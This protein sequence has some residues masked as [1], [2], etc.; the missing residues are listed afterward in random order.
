VGTVPERRCDI[1]MKGGI[2]SG[3]VYPPAVYEIAKH[4]RFVNVGG[5]SA[6]AIAAS[7]T[8]A[9]E[10]RRHVELQKHS[11]NELKG[12]ELLDAIPT[13]LS[14]DAAL[15]GLFRPN[16]KTRTLYEYITRVFQSK[17][18]AATFLRTVG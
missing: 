10:Y 6:G 7:L 9:A 12:F 8:A 4:F 2:T 18:V 17:S 14:K 11:G 1:V 13:D 3:I 15:L 16:S 5:A